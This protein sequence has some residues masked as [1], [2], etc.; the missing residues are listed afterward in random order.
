MGKV[1]K[2]VLG[3]ERI[4]DDGAGELG[5]GGGRG[6]WLWELRGD[7]CKYTRRLDSFRHNSNR[8]W[9]F[10]MD[11]SVPYIQQ[12]TSSTT[13]QNTT[14]QHIQ[15]MHQHQHQLSRWV[16]PFSLKTWN[17]YQDWTRHTK[18]Y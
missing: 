15:H 6:G 1:T 4:S 16:Y 7:D 8:I 5:F 17:E 2:A 10:I 12:T 3:E 14:A 13:L 9:T 11:F 18:V